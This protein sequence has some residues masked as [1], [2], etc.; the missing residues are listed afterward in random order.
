MNSFQNKK[1][2]ITAM[3][4]AKLGSTRLAMKNIALV[5][6]KPLIYYA[7]KAARDSG[8]FDRIVVNAEDA[9]F[10]EIARRYRVDFYKRS[11]SLVKQTTKT[12]SVVY[13]FLKK[14]KCDI[15]AWVSPIAPLQ[16]GEEVRGIADYFIQEGLDSLMTVK[17]EQV[18]CVLNGDPINFRMDEIFAQ[19]QDL[20]PAQYFVYSVMMWRSNT[21][22]REFEGKGYALLCGKVGFYPV[23]RLAAVIVKK[24]EDLMVVDFI[25]RGLS[26]KKGK[27]KVR[28]DRI[29]KGL[30]KRG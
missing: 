9:V 10:S 21:F 30:D 17:E 19:T 25:M 26:S 12:D 11:D 1:Y 5:N 28:Y 4:P 2:K 13:D 20:V 6:G 18:H 29:I 24:E 14:N 15:V 27:Y 22:I 23:S 16:S 8:V 7:I 3:I